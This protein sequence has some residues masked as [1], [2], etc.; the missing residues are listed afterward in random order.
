MNQ[1][2]E[3][4]RK[5]SLNIGHQCLKCQLNIVMQHEQKGT[6]LSLILKNFLL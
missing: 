4:V 6:T 3:K 5:V 2:I 1:G